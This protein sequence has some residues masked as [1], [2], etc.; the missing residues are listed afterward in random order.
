M[1]QPPPLAASTVIDFPP[2]RLDRAA[3]LLYRGADVVALRPKA[4]A[5]L[6][7]LAARPGALVSRDELLAAV[8]PDVTVTDD[9]PRFTVR[10][11]RRVLGDDPAAPRIVATVHGR[12]YRF[13][14]GQSPADEPAPSMPR[15]AAALVGRG[16]ELSSLAAW[17]ARAAAGERSVGLIAGDAGMGKT[18]LVEAF[19]ARLPGDARVAR[20]DCRQAVGSGEPY[21]PL[22]EAVHGLA[23]G[24]D[25]DLVVATLRAHAPTWLAQI[26]SLV[27]PAEG[28]ALRQ[29]TLGS[30]GGRMAR[31]L[32][33]FVGALAAELPLVLVVEDLHWSDGAT[34]DALV[35][36]AH[37]RGPAKLLVLGSYRPVDVVVA[38][39]PFRAVQMDLVRRGLAREV[40][41]SLLDASAVQTYL[42]ARFGEVPPAVVRF[43]AERSDGNPLFMTA[44]ADHLAPKAWPTD[45]SDVGI[46]DTLRGM[47]ERQLE[48]LTPFA[49]S[50]LEVASVAG[51]EFDT[52]SVVTALG[53]LDPEIVE[54]ACEDLA[55]R[56]RVLRFLVDRTWAD[57]SRGARFA[58]AHALY[59]DVLY[60]RLPA[61]RRA[62]L[63]QLVGERLER[64]VAG[65]A[66]PGAVAAEL[67]GHFERSGDAA[68][69]VAWLGRAAQVAQR[70]FADREA[71][72]T[73][74][75]A[76]ALLPA[77]PEA[78]WTEITLR[79]A[80]GYSLAAV[81][82]ERSPALAVSGA[83][84]RTLAE[85]A[86]ESPAGIVALFAILTPELGGGHIAAGSATAARILDLS[87]RIAPEFSP[88]GH[89]TV[90]MT[91]CYA[92][93][94][95][96]A[97]RHLEACSRDGT[98]G[99]WAV[100]A[101]PVLIVLTHL[102]ELA[103]LPLGH[104]RE[105]LAL[106]DESLA[107][108]ERL[109]HPYARVMAWNAAANIFAQLGDAATAL[110]YATQGDELC[111]RYDVPSFA[112]RVALV[113]AAMQARREEAC[114]SPA[115]IAGWLGVYE[116]IGLI[117][118]SVGLLYAIEIAAAG[119]RLD[120]AIEYAEEGLRF[121]EATGERM[122]EAELLRWRGELE[123]RRK[124]GLAARPW[125]ERALDVASAGDARWF[126]L[127][128]ATRLAG[129]ERGGARAAS[130]ERL[131]ELVA[132]FDADDQ[133]PD[134]RAA[135]AV[136]ARA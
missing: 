109:R 126:A 1:S 104:P 68:R 5:V 51:V 41:L 32:A 72:E 20:G 6:A 120:E 28:A 50:L 103:L 17:F 80:M 42:Q 63:H 48:T 133:W 27:D 121:A 124:K 135:R 84:L 60:E 94:F 100:A 87:E 47:I 40:A 71:V 102:S 49:R 78:A 134:L 96:A 13:I 25:R 130:R 98:P 77:G 74:A 2:F 8:W 97:R 107:W 46:P 91:R 79:Q 123:L 132:T 66:D 59:R 24:R 112:H 23:A 111:A 67:G 12:G 90:G 55:R 69:A 4:F 119:G 65:D 52:Q 136:L 113:R 127:R 57:G 14:G 117:G 26:P 11:L 30:T 131:G 29:Q 99:E 7:H 36:V 37:A 56:T 18:T 19:L 108:A 64:G 31:E 89:L 39:H 85:E 88:L 16:P 33:A 58:F 75:R 129:G 3:G 9:A 115:Q 101:D 70:R 34:L 82:G 35:A 45:F 44:L 73:F 116:G 38:A 125:F 10:E 83:R 53:E 86:G 21:Q 43:V 62:R 15:A 105:A 76:L 106:N 54:D 118:K 122:R 114:A 95:V 93:D 61:S 92:G 110:G 81:D 22:L 128:A